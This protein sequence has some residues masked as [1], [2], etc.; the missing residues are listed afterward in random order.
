MQQ[1]LDPNNN[2]SKQITQT[3]STKSQIFNNKTN[4]TLES[5]Y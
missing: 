2:V 1:Y 5:Y 3:V 4:V